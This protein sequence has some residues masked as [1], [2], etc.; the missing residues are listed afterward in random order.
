[1]LIGTLVTIAS[2]VPI[3][4]ARSSAGEYTFS[5]FSVVGDLADR[6]VAGRGDLRA[7]DRQGD[8]EGAQGRTPTPSRASCSTRYSAFLRG[9]I[10]AKWVTIGA[11]DRRVRRGDLPVA[12]RAAAVLPG[13]RPARADGR[14]D[15]AAERVDLRDRGAGQ[16]PRGAPEGRPRRRPLQHLRRPR[17]DPLHPARST[18]SSRIR[19]SR[20]S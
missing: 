11:D 13:L 7:A 5:I 14:P 4:F 16:A 10:R 3:G 20:S 6:V 2:F 9:A 19:S 8:P 12:V 17:R 18:C 15:A 1:M